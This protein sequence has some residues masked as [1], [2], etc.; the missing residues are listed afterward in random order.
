[1]A[2]YL[3]TPYE[4]SRS[5]KIFQNVQ[6]K[7]I[8]DYFI[9][10]QYEEEYNNNVPQLIKYLTSIFSRKIFP[11]PLL[12]IKQDMNLASAIEKEYPF[13]IVWTNMIFRASE[14][15]FE[16]TAFHK[17]CDNPKLSHQLIIV[18]SNWKNIFGACTGHSF[19]KSQ[20]IDPLALGTDLK[21]QNMADENDRTIL[22]VSKSDNETI[23]NRIEKEGPLLFHIKPQQTK[24]AVWCGIDFAG[25]A[26]GVGFDLYI[27]DKCNIK[28]DAGEYGFVYRNSSRLSSFY[29]ESVERVALCGGNAHLSEEDADANEFMFDVEEYE[30]FELI[31]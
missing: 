16:A 4:D 8:S 13:H 24:W 27:A 14:H 26:F 18:K 2:Q 23:Q 11:S 3:S 29:N 5:R 9:R 10:T 25:P 15:N 21:R 22:F 7:K 17:V 28:W 31:H 1:M 20:T 30:V 19:G 6:S 12:T